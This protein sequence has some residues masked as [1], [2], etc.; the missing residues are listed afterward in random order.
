MDAE[1]WMRTV[2]RELHTAQCHHLGRIQGQLLSLPCARG[3]D[4]SE[5]VGVSRPKTRSPVRQ[6]VQGQVSAAVTLCPRRCQHGCQEAV[7]LLERIG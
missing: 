7:P 4:D 2:E 6:R 3:T 1:D 5:E